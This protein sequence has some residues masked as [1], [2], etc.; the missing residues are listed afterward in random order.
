MENMHSGTLL[1]RYPLAIFGLT[2]NNWRKW[3]SK[4]YSSCVTGCD[5][6]SIACCQHLKG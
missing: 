6:Y 5:L 3:K 1:W 2:E 4:S